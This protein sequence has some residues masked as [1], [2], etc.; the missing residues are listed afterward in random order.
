M[1]ERVRWDV[2]GVGENSADY[3]NL[4]DTL[5]Q[6]GAS[7]SKI[8][9]RERRVLCGGQMATA[10][11]TC[12]SLGLRAKYVG[13]IGADDNGRR[14]RNELGRH[15]VDIA[16]LAERSVATRT[17][18]IFVHRSTGDRLIAWH[19]DPGLNLRDEEIPLDDLGRARVVHVDQTDEAAA[20]RAARAGRAAQA[21]VTTDI[22]GVA[23][24]TVELAGLAT[25]AIFAEDVPRQLTGEAD[26]E[27]ALRA[28]RRTTQATLVVTLG[29]RGSVALDADRWHHEPA[30]DVS[31]VDTTG[32]GDV[33]RGGY[34]YGVL[35]GE[36]IGRA[37]RLANTA[38]AVSCTRVG[39]LNGVPALNEIAHLM[40]G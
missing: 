17:A 40:E 24:V 18:V 8:E 23:G 32:A 34:I 1:N 35:Q 31:A 26:L 4:V 3:V 27:R 14:L 7:Q 11:C 30:V 22:D 12:A 29:N 15:G 38:A 16:H 13:V 36:P 5:P 2:V 21:I 10:L 6:P 28:I 19:R 39:A 25:H 33:F 9:I 37:L 20:L